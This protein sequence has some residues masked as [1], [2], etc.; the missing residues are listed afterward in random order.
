MKIRDRV[1]AISFL[2]CIIPMTFM[3]VFINSIVSSELKK[4]EQYR[5]ETTLRSVNE[6]L[7]SLVIDVNNSVDNIAYII[8]SHRDSHMNEYLLEQMRNYGSMREEV[9]GYYFSDPRGRFFS[10]W[11]R[12]EEEL[13][14]LISN[15]FIIEGYDPRERPWYMSAKIADK[16]IISDPYLDAFDG[17]IVITASKRIGDLNDFRGV[18]GVDFNFFPIA[19]ELH[20]LNPWSTG[21][22]LITTNKGKLIIDANSIDD[23]YNDNKSII[24]SGISGE[25]K[26]L[27]DKDI[28]F[29]IIPL[30]HFD[31]KLIG[32]YSEKE[33]YSTLTNIRRTIFITMLLSLLFSTVIIAIFGRKL[34]NSLDRLS[35]LINSIARGNYT[36]NIDKLSSIIDDESELFL[37]KE[38]VKNMQA[39]I[40]SRELQLKNNAEV[41]GLTNILNR[42]TILDILEV[43]I[44]RAKSFSTEFSIIM[45]DYDN[46]KSL[47]DSYGHLFGDQVLIEVSKYIKDSLKEDDF[48]GRYGGEEFII[49]LPDTVLVDAVKVGERIRKTIENMVWETGTVV[50]VSCG[51]VQES[52]EKTVEEI[53]KKADVLLYKAKN[54]GRNRIEY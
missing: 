38:A 46:F 48:V 3:G 40:Q 36:K 45:F 23:F 43:E 34:S 53:I 2:S 33:I 15:D 13:K 19:Q 7:G 35:Y 29:K 42:K 26:S 24:K 31:F 50:T 32:V 16:L 22:F 1:Y 28:N 25:Q 5:T 6:Y 8:D 47:N 11:P 30:D 52:G 9:E 44:R 37:V 51:I 41:D 54:N 4:E 27:H 39:E 17:D 14:D 10:G 49:I 21:G 12:S 20:G 18:I